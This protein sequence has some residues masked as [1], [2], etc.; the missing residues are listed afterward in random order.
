MR[1]GEGVLVQILGS[2]RIWRDGQEI[3]LGATSRRT[4]LGI[5]A[6]ANGQSV[7]RSD[8]ADSLWGEH[9]PASAANVIQTHIKH[10]RRLLEPHRPARSPSN[11]LPSMGDGYAL[12]LPDGRLDLA[13]FRSLVAT[14][15]QVRAEG[16]EHRAAA[17]LAEALRLWHGPPFADVPALARHPKAVALEV[18][19]R[20]VLARCGDMMINIG[21]AA[22]ALPLLEEAA[23][24]Q[25]LDEDAQARLIR[26][27]HAVGQRG[28]AF[29]TYHATRRRLADELGVDPGLNLASTH[30]ALLTDAAPAAPARPPAA[31]P[32]PAQL[33]ADIR[34]FTGRVSELRELDTLLDENGP[35]M[36]ICVIS[37]TAGVG[38]TAL[39]L[40]WAHRA[41]ARF[42]DGQLYVD[43]R[44]YDPKQPASA[45]DVL[46]RFLTA[47]GVPADSIPLDLEGRAERYRTEMADRRALVVLDNG[48]SPDQIRP[49]LPGAPSC[50]VLV[51]SRSSLA[52]LVT[53]HGAYRLSLDLL[54]IQDATS[55]LRRLIG[56]RAQSE[57]QATAVLAEQCARLPLALRL[58]AELASTQPTTRLADLVRELEDQRRRLRWLDAGGDPRAAARAVFSWSYRHLP[59][60]VA[61]A[62][63]RA[64]IHPGP[65][66]EPYAMAALN[67]A[68]LPAAD[69]MLTQLTRAHLVQPA[70][71]GRFSMH[72]LLRAYAAE[73][74]EAE[75]TAADRAQA[76][77]R[78]LD[79][80]L[81]TIIVAMDLLHP[82][83][84]HHRPQVADPGTPA[85]P[86]PDP[87]QARGWLDAELPTLTVICGYAATH[88]WPT[89]AIRF[90]TA[91][92]RYLESAP[93]ADALTIHTHALHAARRIDDT[94]GQ[95]HALTNIGSVYRLQGQYRPAITH[96]ERALALH[97]QT[98]DGYGI[99]RTL[100]HLGIVY[101]RLGDYR[102]SVR[103]QEQAL[104]AY[105]QIA[106][107]YGEAG[108]LINLGTANGYLGRHDLSSEN[109]QDG[110][111]IFH[112]IGERSGE[113][114]GLANLGDLYNQLGRHHE[115]AE[116]LER[117]LVLFRELGHRY[118]EATTLA[119]ASAAQVQIGRY[120]QARENLEQA[121]TMYR[122]L[123]HRYGEASALNGLG[124]LLHA[125]GRPHEALYHHNAALTLAVETGDRDEQ[126]RAQHG[127]DRARQPRPGDPG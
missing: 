78:L 71:A 81:F 87:A 99:A 36:P 120:E 10:L 110:L 27:Y 124:E 76:I 47:L 66:L 51:T 8:I 111:T 20:S 38:K 92:F 58:A 93:Y 119:N 121:L 9:P 61:T 45:D 15:M 91:L 37:G 105:R 7:H 86:M 126:T 14:A 122:D 89:H 56:A 30:T 62:F 22:D 5:L 90:S 75:D 123:G 68:D 4:V 63:R 88:D 102:R 115:A 18:E 12:C 59:D 32:V 19:R 74:S 21:M 55:L 25:P 116:H 35:G 42:P 67:D 107:R 127:I 79:H 43:L 101:E 33:P 17:L 98:G 3:G 84:R 69:Q 103:Y 60:R 108:S 31:H 29:A 44:G 80:Y 73:L 83:D 52:G 39:I 24:A 95:A 112:E 41:R 26:A 40:H 70:G 23:A 11:I 1:A 104:A 114:I 64:G 113:A 125:T 53:L 109:L 77:G 57:E 2:V 50:A 28:R 6:L 96:L 85:P 13:R 97:R 117:A 106:D 16:D 54:T 82:G 48:A 118:G 100:S 72:D 46:V 65:S 49:L 94:A 34:D